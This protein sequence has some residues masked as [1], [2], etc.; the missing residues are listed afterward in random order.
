MI[1]DFSRLYSSLVKVKSGLTGS[2]VW[3]NVGHSNYSYIITAKHNI[4]SESVIAYDRNGTELLIEKPIPLDGMDISI[5]KVEGRC[6]NDVELCLGDNR[7]VS[8]NSNCLILGHPKSLV[9]I[10]E[11]EVMEHQGTII[12]NE[13]KISFKISDI[14]PEYKNRDHAEG[15]SGGPIFEIDN[16][17]FYLKGIITDTFDEDFSYQKVKGIRT[18]NIYNGL[19]ETVKEEFLCENDLSDL[20]DQSCES[21]GQYIQEYILEN[22]FIEMLSS[23]DIS[24]LKECEHFYL[25]DDKPR[26]TQHL[27]LLRNKDAIKSYIHSRVLAKIMNE[28]LVVYDINPVSSSKQKIFTIHVTDFTDEDE[29]A[30]K[31]IKQDNSIDY[32]NSILLIIYSS[33]DNNLKYIKKRRIEKMIANFTKVPGLYDEKAKVS[34]KMAVRN[35]LE[36][37]KK[38]GVKFS[39]MNMKFLV[40]MIVARV[41]NELDNDD[42]DREI[43]KSEVISEVALYD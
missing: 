27:S 41:K 43:V 2:G 34:E 24:Y 33:D 15:F 7:E 32:S 9:K 12:L 26:K 6:P 31:L 36:G 10:S 30:A 8:K 11:D 37:H 21:L 19:P 28:D 29:L 39:V 3:I 22:G 14:L 5:I 18:S 16:E 42:Y 4:N 35:F 17:R 23:L 20:V 40:D 13:G 1:I 25:A 38:K